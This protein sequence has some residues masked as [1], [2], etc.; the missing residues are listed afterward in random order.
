M[1]TQTITLGDYTI[2]VVVTRP[3]WHENCYVVRHA[4]TGEMVVLD[5]GGDGDRIAEAVRA[6]PGTLKEIWLTH[7]HPD[8]IGAVREL[9]TAFGVPCRAHRD[10]KR[11]LELAAELAWQLM[12]EDLDGPENC[13]YFENEP[14]LTLGGIGVRAISTPGHTPGGVSYAFD[15]FVITGDTLFNHGIGRTDLPG[16]SARQL[17]S[18]ITRLL[19]SLPPDTRLFSGHGPPWLAGEARQWWKTVAG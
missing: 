19:D 15:G 1:S 9:Q 5:P 2:T 14:V 12:E 3:P 16:G 18:S 11:T 6:Q 4:P 10:E 17:Q 7:G 13:Q 8:H